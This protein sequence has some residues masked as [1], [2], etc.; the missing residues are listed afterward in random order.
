LNLKS[1]IIIRY[2]TIAILN[3]HQMVRLI[4]KC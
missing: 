3:I 1:K 2:Y 4:L